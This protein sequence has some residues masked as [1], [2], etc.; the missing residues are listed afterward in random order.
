MRRLRA[1]NKLSYIAVFVLLI[2]SCTLFADVL[3]HHETA[4]TANV[5]DHNYKHKHVSI[6]K[7][8]AACDICTHL[9]NRQI[10]HHS[11]A[12][13][14]NFA[15]HATNRATVFTYDFA[16]IYSTS[17]YCYLTRGPPV[18]LFS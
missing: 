8:K 17:F 10:Q 6:S 16:A 15:L 7:A 9:N 14:L 2:F 5:C 12:Y 4:S 11:D 18:L 3:H 1:H 13:V